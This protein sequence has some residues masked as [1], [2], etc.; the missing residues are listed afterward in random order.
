MFEEQAG[1]PDQGQLESAVLG[2]WRERDIFGKL[3][4]RN[5]GRAQFSF[6][7]GPITANNPM[8]VHHAWGRTYKDIFQ[9]YR[10]MKG[11]N[12]RFQN[13]FDCQGL[14]VE[15][16]VEKELGFGSKRDIESYGVDAF[17]R[18]CKERVHQY[19]KLQTAS[20]IRIGMWMRSWPRCK[21]RVSTPAWSRTSRTSRAI[22]NWHIGV[23]SA[24]SSTV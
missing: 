16:E 14:W 11:F 23:I 22:R 12:Q 5:R 13:G 4:G 20:S 18:K 24:K 9:R 15:V 19:S 10:G 1:L 3:R 8:G 21:L 6:L 17:V 2:F 7:D